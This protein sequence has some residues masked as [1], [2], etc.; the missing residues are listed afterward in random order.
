ME[1]VHGAGWERLAA[2]ESAAARRRAGCSIVARLPP[3]KT[4][5]QTAKLKPEQASFHSFCPTSTLSPLGLR[6]GVKGGGQAMEGAE[7]R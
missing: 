1:R 4:A 2:A 6:A 5:S 3:Q 7:R